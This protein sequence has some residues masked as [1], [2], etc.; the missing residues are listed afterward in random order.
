MNRMIILIFC[1][2]LMFAGCSI[3]N[4]LTRDFNT[5]EKSLYYV[6][7][8]EFQSDKNNV[9][10]VLDSISAVED[11]PYHANITV[12]KKPPIPL[13]TNIYTYGC[14]LGRINYEEDLRDFLK[15]SYAI[16]AYRAGNFIVNPDSLQRRKIR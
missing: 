6:H 3:Q 8:S 2:G 14:E 10:V 11:I 15:E 13:L 7:D 1:L 5:F 12:L 16:E 9:S 4:E